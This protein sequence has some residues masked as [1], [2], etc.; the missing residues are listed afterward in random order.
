[1]EI[2]KLNDIEEIILN[3]NKNNFNEIDDKYIEL[4]IKKYNEE[5][6]NYMF[7]LY[8]N[9]EVDKIKLEEKIKRYDK[10][11]K[12]KVIDYYK[13]CIVTGRSKSVCEVAHI[14]PFSKSNNFQKYDEYNGILLCRDLHILFDNKLISI[15]PTDFRLVLSPEIFHDD[16]L[17]IYH[18][19]Y[20]NILNIREESRKYFN[21]INKLN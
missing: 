19:Y 7:Y 14:L 9:Y 20:N 17:K 18:K 2:N 12:N 1:M 4:L 11:F 5:E 8:F 6:L 15:N 10:D 3:I 16:T 13:T 21:L